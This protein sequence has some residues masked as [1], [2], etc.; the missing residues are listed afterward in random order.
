MKRKIKWAKE[1]MKRQILVIFCAVCAPLYKLPPPPPGFFFGIL[2]LFV[3]QFSNRQNS[4]LPRPPR[5]SLSDSKPL[6]RKLEI[7]KTACFLL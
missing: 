4:H 5:L 7:N 3:Q 6:R 1:E 2:L